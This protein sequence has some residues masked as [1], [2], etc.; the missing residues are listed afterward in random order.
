[1]AAVRFM[2]IANGLLTGIHVGS[3]ELWIR[4]LSTIR[5]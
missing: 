4:T 1:M 5:L 2:Q 3:S